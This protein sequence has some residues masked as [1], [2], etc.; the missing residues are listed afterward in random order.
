MIRGPVLIPSRCT[1]AS[2]GPPLASWHLLDLGLRHAGLKLAQLIMDGL[3][4]KVYQERIFAKMLLDRLEHEEALEAAKAK[5]KG[6]GGGGIRVILPNPSS[7]L[8]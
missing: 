7:I 6:T 5:E 2:L 4:G 8:S 1:T 3:A